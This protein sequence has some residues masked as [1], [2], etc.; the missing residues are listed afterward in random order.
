MKVKCYLACSNSNGERYKMESRSNMVRWLTPANIHCVRSLGMMATLS[1]L[2][3]KFICCCSLIVS[4]PILS[5]SI[6]LASKVSKL[7]RSSRRAPG[8][9]SKQFDLLISCSKWN[10][11]EM[12]L[13]RIV[14]Y[15]Y[16]SLLLNS[17]SAAVR[18]PGLARNRCLA[19]SDRMHL[20]SS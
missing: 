7:A 3:F 5:M 10:W 8:G 11:V 12:T 1:E 13:N 9:K 17:F 6:I 18:R 19:L 16:E 14:I 15:K 2:N 4:A 20:Q